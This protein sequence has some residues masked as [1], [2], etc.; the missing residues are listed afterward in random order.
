MAYTYYIG[1]LTLMVVGIVFWMYPPK[2]L[3]E[4]YGYRTANGIRNIEPN[5]SASRLSKSSSRKLLPNWKRNGIGLLKP[6]L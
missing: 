1:A 5:V 6:I 2:K 3:N 4:F